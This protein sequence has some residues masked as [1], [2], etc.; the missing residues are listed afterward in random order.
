M[1]TPHPLA[2]R[3]FALEDDLQ[4]YIHGSG[5]SVFDATDV[6]K[7]K[8]AAQVKSSKIAISADA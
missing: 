1:T 7:R 8:H 3:Q 4:L 5:N 2:V 6:K